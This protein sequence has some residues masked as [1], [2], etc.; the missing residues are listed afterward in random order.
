MLAFWD[1]VD[2]SGDCW[3]WVASC[4]STGYGK[5]TYKRKTY[6]AHR[7]VFSLLGIEIPD[8]M[9]VLHRCDNRKCVNPKHLFFGTI[10]D[11]NRDKCKKGRQKTPF[12]EKNGS[13]VLA[14]EQV[15]VIRE[16]EGLVSPGRIAEKFGCSRTT[17]RRILSGECWSHV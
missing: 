5:L 8:G 16:L 10:A 3:E 14:A 6:S 11:N 1:K 17:V 15:V 4:S 13:S 9:C 7:F 2:K 12:G